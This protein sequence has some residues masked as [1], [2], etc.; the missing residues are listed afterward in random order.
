MAEGAGVGDSTART[1]RAAGASRVARLLTM[2]LLLAELLLTLLELALVGLPMVLL[3]RDGIGA[4]G[5][6]PALVP[7]LAGLWLL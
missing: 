6:A 7:W 1:A 2:R 4:S 3:V 5:A